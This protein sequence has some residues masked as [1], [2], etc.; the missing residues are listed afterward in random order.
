MKATPTLFRLTA[1][2]SALE[3][4]ALQ[5]G[6]ER[7]ETH[8]SVVSKL[9]EQFKLSCFPCGQSASCD[10]RSRRS[11]GKRPSQTSR[12]PSSG[13]DYIECGDS[14]LSPPLWTTRIPTSWACRNQIRS[15]PKNQRAAA[16]VR[17]MS[18]G[19]TTS[20]SIEAGDF[21]HARHRPSS[22]RRTLPL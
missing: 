1:A 11:T 18:G 8:S 17:Q 6:S 21:C 3:V 13:H 10:R 20:S 12:S 2:L 4:S 7:N 14:P 22:T 5:A 16:L 15:G 9:N 19:T